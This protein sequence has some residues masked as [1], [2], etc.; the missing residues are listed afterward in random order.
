MKKLL[1]VPL[2]LLAIGMLVAVESAP[3][4]VVGYVK[5]DC[6]VGDNFVAM[7]MV[8]SFTNTVEFGAPYGDDINTILIWDPANQIWQTSTNY[9][10]GYW[11]PELPV[12]T[13]SVLFFNTFSPLT[14]YSIGNLPATNAQ[15]NI[16]EGD[17][18][19]MVPL[20]KSALTNTMQVGGTIGDGEIVNTILLWDSAN[21]IWATSTNYGSGYWEPELP[22]SIGMPLYLNSFENV[23]WPAGPRGLSSGLGTKNK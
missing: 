19:V 14:Y 17:N 12:G 6:V 8:Q 5:Y 22:V 18:T 13:N 9:G 23:V 11:E 16:V 7:P 21:Q 4:N 2:L 1:I 3:S 20:N 10:S 15:F